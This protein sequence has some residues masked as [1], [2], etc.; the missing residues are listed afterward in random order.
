MKFLR[1]LYVSEDL[2][3]QAAQITEDLKNGKYGTANHYLLTCDLHKNGQLEVLPL[4]LIR[5]GALR[6][7]LPLIIGIA[8]SKDAGIEMI[9]AIITGILSE[10]G[11]LD[12]G[13]Y[14]RN[15]PTVSSRG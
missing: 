2:I 3:T 9:S 8:S 13:S 5:Q 14:F 15:K 4:Q 6:E 1:D 12:Y 11:S 7:R 10:T